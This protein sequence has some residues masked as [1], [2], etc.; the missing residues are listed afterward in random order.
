[1]P[2]IAGSGSISQRHRSADPD[3]Y[4]NVTD[5]QKCPAHRFLVE[6]EHSI[7][8]EQIFFHFTGGK[9]YLTWR[10][11]PMQRMRRPQYRLAPMLEKSL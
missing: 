8:L 9:N 5:L 6:T 3:P 11:P 10:K 7:L 4:Q 1:M 2:K